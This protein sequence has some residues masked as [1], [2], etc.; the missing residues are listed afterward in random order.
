MAREKAETD[1]ASVNV[2]AK[3]SELK[4]ARLPLKIIGT[5]PLISHAW[6][7]KAKIMMLNKQQKKANEGQE[8]RRPHVEFADSLYWL[9]PKPDLD[10]YTD[11]EAKKI[12]DEIIPQSKFGFPTLAF[13]AAALDAGFQQGALVKNAGTKD[14]AKTTARGAIFIE[15]DFAV[16]EGTPTMRE[17]IAR[18]GSGTADLRYRAEFKTWSTELKIQFNASVLSVEQ[19]VNLFRL[20]GFANGV[21]DWRPARDGSFGTF[22]VG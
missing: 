8:I 15:E 14:L 2:V 20:G 9:T 10:A 6:S 19:V 22:I 1:G 16:I 12:L 5:S 13:K 17:D 3:L 7:E 4:I 18:I 21:G 11:E